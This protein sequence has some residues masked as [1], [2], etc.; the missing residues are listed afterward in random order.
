MKYNWNS[1]EIWIVSKNVLSVLTVL[2]MGT[3]YLISNNEETN[4]EASTLCTMYLEL[5][6]LPT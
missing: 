4:I 1:Y 5:Q 6:F 2:D 3:S